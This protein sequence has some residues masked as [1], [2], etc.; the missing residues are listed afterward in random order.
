MRRDKT[1][2]VA[3]AFHSPIRGYSGRLPGGISI[4]HLENLRVV[5][6]REHDFLQGF[7]RRSDVPIHSLGCPFRVGLK[8]GP[9]DREMLRNVI[10]AE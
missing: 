9:N 1:L 4:N 3:V 10:G 8:Q 2:K 7:R 6:V 5:R